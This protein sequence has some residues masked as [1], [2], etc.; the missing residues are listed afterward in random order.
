MLILKFLQRNRF[1]YKTYTS[2]K[3]KKYCSVMTGKNGSNVEING[4]DLDKI[5]AKKKK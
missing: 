2:V 1:C 3:T 4:N 5:L